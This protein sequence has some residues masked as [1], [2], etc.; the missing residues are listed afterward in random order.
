MD[1]VYALGQRPVGAG[2]APRGSAIGGLLPLIL[3]FL[4]FYFLLIRPQQRKVREHQKLLNALKRG[5]EVITSGGIHGTITAIKGNVVDL[6]IA[7]E[8]KMVL[9][10][11]A[12]ATVIES[13]A[14]SNQ[15]KETR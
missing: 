9:S 6:K 4:V 11:N 2:D 14:T 5:D 8:V 13:P 12:I 7:E 3:I 10:K 1:L 15:E